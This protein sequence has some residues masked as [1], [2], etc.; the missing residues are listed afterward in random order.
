MDFDAG[1]RRDPASQVGLASAVALMA[2]K[3]VTAQGD[4]PALDENGLGQAWADLGASFG[5]QAGRDSFS[6][7][8]RSLTEPALLQRA[9]ALAARQIDRKSTRLNSSHLVISYAV[10]CL[11][12]KK[13]T[14]LGTRS[15]TVVSVRHSM[16]AI[17][18]PAYA[19]PPARL[20]IWTPR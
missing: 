20:S 15:V 13:R 6:Y 12:K 10:F 3:G 11:K 1:S 4:A 14:R 2:S 18:S 19:I 9:V 5:A 16:P 17:I 7:G 8:L